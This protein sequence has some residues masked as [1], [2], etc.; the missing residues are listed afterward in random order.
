MISN[1]FIFRNL[2]IFS[3]F[4]SNVVAFAATTTAPDSAKLTLPSPVPQKAGYIL[5]TG[6][7]PFGWRDKPGSWVWNMFMDTASQR[8]L[9]NYSAAAQ[10]TPQTVRRYGG[11]ELND[12]FITPTSNPVVSSTGYT[13]NVQI[14]T[15]SS[16]GDT[17]SNAGFSWVLYCMPSASYSS[18]IN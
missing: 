7:I 16:G 5:A 1:L 3:F 10:V 14:Q 8:C 17:G 9:P 18:S 13:M 4:F 6:S 15:N 12:F 2:L 11:G